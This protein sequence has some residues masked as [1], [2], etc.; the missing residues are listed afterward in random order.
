MIP[1]LR[2]SLQEDIK[3]YLEIKEEYNRRGNDPIKVC[4]DFYV[5]LYN[6]WA[7]M[8][9]IVKYAKTTGKAEWE[10]LRDDMQ[11]SVR[12][13]FTIKFFGHI[14]T[15][16]NCIAKW[17]FTRPLICMILPEV[18]P[19]KKIIS[20]KMTKKEVESAWDHPTLRRLADRVLARD[21]FSEWM[22]IINSN[23]NKIT[24]K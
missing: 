7:K 5:N 8:M 23:Q 4:K 21:E 20:N 19:I 12:A 17:M 3:K 22:H 10:L 6:I 16:S 24:K 1:E 15:Q 14:Q 9:C 13:S 2:L 11:S 18:V